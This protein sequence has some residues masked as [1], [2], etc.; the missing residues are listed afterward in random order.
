MT[1]WPAT[2]SVEHRETLRAAP[3]AAFVAAGGFAVEG[4]I[5]LVHHTADHNWDA[6]SQ[7]LNGAYALAAL[8]LIVALP[9]VGRW[10]QVAR[11]GRGGVI[12]AQ[13]GYA[14]MVVES[15][16]SGVNDG[17]TL[18]GVFFVGLLLSLLG[19]LLLGIDAVIRGNRRWAALLPLLGM[20]V[21]IAGGE[22]GGSIASGAVWLVLGTSLMRSETDE[23]TAGL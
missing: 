8:A 5:S 23:A 3:T 17:N 13:I 15:V 4:F 20:F 19:L 2:T 14:A 22:H 18:G 12:T 6:P 1:A 16:V 10:L 21:G 11:L 7:V 9:A